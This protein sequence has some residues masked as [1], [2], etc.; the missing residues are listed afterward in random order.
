MNNEEARRDVRA[1][2]DVV[3]DASQSDAALEKESFAIEPLL[4]KPPDFG[5]GEPPY[6]CQNLKHIL[7]MD[8][9]ERHARVGRQYSGVCTRS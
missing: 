3:N 2:T 9:L 6:P 8:D 5:S 1:L 7:E 4:M